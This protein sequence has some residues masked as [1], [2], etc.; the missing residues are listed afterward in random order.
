[1]SSCTRINQNIW[2]VLKIKCV[3]QSSDDQEKTDKETLVV[4]PVILKLHSGFLYREAQVQ[5]NFRGSDQNRTNQISAETNPA[6]PSLYWNQHCKSERDNWCIFIKGAQSQHGR[7]KQRQI[8]TMS[9]SA[10]WFHRPPPHKAHLLLWQQPLLNVRCVHFIKLTADGG[11]LQ[12]HHVGKLMKTILNNA[13]FCTSFSTFKINSWTLYTN[14]HLH[15]TV[16]SCS[17]S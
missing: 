5:V 3:F 14:L 7:V 1:M 17:H 11:Q 16:N 8:T 12:Q 4:W 10:R 13:D 2:T 9:F 6:S 15:R